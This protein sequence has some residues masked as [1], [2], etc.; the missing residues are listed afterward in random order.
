MPVTHPIYGGRSVMDLNLVDVESVEL[1]TGAFNAE[2]GQAQSG[3]V[4]IITRER[5]RTATRAASSTRPT[6]SGVFG[7]SY[8][9]DY[10]SLYI[11]GPEPITQ[12]L[13]PALGID[14]GTRADLLPLRQR[15]ADQYRVRQRTDAR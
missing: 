3:V 4:N 5:R 9:T 13:L 12:T 10:A 15:N 7:E 14:P 2:Y 8:N 11:G 1:L 6:G